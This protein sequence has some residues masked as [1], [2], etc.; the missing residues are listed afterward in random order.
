M[1]KD[2]ICCGRKSKKDLW[3]SQIVMS[4]W[5]KMSGGRITTD[6]N[7]QDMAFSKMDSLTTEVLN[8]LK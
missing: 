2:K 3:R 5:D 4:N 7:D 8:K 6:F 1:N